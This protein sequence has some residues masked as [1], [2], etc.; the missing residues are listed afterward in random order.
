MPDRLGIVAGSP[1]NAR[2]GLANRRSRAKFATLVTVRRFVVPVCLLLAL[3]VALA[4]QARAAD[5]P[6]LGDSDDDITL[7]TD[8]SVFTLTPRVML[9]P[10]RTCLN[11]S[12]P[13]VTS[14]RGRLVIA[15]LFRP[16]IVGA[17]SVAVA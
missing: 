3:C 5:A 4:G 16:P 11:T 1:R 8:D 13:P 2:G 10:P 14:G 17:S 15:D 6:S 7:G 12:P 9:P